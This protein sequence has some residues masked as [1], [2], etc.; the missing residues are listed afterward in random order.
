M[1]YIAGQHMVVDGHVQDAA[2]LDSGNV[3]R[4]FD[5][6]VDT[7]HMQYLMRPVACEVPLSAAN[8]RTEED[9][10]GTSFICQ[11]TTSHIAVHTWPLRG[12]VMMDIMSCKDFDADLAARVIHD[13]LRFRAW[14]C[15]YFYRADPDL[16]LE[17]H[18]LVHIPIPVIP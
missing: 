1:R 13:H 8:L 18:D 17:H 6:L 2:T 5:V 10:G 7:L 16:S 4:M 14:R 9:D 15:H 3:L 11:I 12:S